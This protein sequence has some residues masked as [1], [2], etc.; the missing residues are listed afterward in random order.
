MSNWT[1]IRGVITV[2]PFG[3][4]QAEKRYILDTVLE[5]LPRVTGSEG[6]MEVHVI[7]RSGHDESHSEDEFGM[8]TNN[9][10]NWWTGRTRSREH[11]R[12][13]LQ[14][15][16]F[17]VV[18]ADLR[19]RVFEETK[20]EFVKWLVRLAKRVFV[21][22]VLVTVEDRLYKKWLI[23]EDR[24]FWDLHEPP[25]WSP[26]YIADEKKRDFVGPNWCEYLMWDR[27]YNTDM[28]LKLT[29]KYYQ[30]AENDAEFFRRERWNE[31]A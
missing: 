4:T 18:E 31:D 7:Q 14:N 16:Y 3:R 1:H 24:K 2:S 25:T 19:D 10:I 13:E 8:C 20:K 15:E 23:N 26:D 30:S 28:P 27:G 12:L 5:H 22:A 6:D 17:L 9:L 29:Y 21:D 11:G